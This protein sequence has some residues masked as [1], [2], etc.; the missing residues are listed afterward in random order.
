MKR[1]FVFT[2]GEIFP[3]YITERPESGDIVIAADSGYN[4]AKSMGVSVDILV[5]DFDSLK[6][7]IPSDVP[8][9]LKLPAK[10]DLTDTQLAVEKAVKEGATDITIIG[11]LS[12]R[13][14]HTLSTLAI[15]EDLLERGIRGVIVSGQNRTVYIKNTNHIIMRGDYKYFSLIATDTAKGVSIEGAVYPLK[16]K[17][18]E[19]RKQFAVSNEIDGNCALVTVKKG[20]L[21][22]IE[23]RDI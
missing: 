6:G 13:L 7:E 9:V 10:K 17:T 22:I 2:G 23:S 16:N 14:D 20:G 12:G 8:E 4:N 3:Q 21:Y 1:G 5:G 19:R 11:S 15:L 18:L